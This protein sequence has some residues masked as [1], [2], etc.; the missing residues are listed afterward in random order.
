[1][2]VDPGI[3]TLAALHA[4]LTADGRER[5]VA[6]SG[7]SWRN[8]THAERRLAQAALWCAPLLPSY[9]R[10]AAVTAKTG[11][12][13]RYVAYLR[14]ALD[15]RPG[16]LAET[17]KPRWA[18]AAFNAWDAAQ[19][20]RARFWGRAAVGCLADGDAGVPRVFAYGSAF[21]GFK[22]MRG[23]R[24]GPSTAMFKAARTAAGAVRAGG[25]QGGAVQVTEHRSTLC[26]ARHAWAMARVWVR[27][28]ESGREQRKA[29]RRPARPR[30][31]PRKWRELHGLRFCQ[32][33]NA[34][35]SRDGDAARSI[36]DWAAAAAAG[37]SLRY[38][39]RGPHG[40]D[41]P[42]P[43]RYVLHRPPPPAAAAAA[44]PLPPL[45]VS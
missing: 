29:D 32:V 36:R 42:R 37:Y 8:Q 14:V 31:P 43:P 25:V 7:D 23:T 5:N 44:V 38:M 39:E 27:V 40:E 26:C 11:S 1:V 24:P 12:P 13:E 20:Q 33:C 10:L 9:A 3:G 4:L 21:T 18:R 28:G 16:I 22:G 6:M 41:G 45:G 15:V 2:G 34:L 17:T 19:T 30:R 35:V